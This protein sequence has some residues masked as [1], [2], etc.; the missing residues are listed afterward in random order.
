MAGRYSLSNKRYKRLFQRHDN[1]IAERQIDKFNQPETTAYLKKIGITKAG[2]IKKIW[3]ATK[4]YPYYLNLIRKQKDNGKP[5]KLS[6][7]GRDMVDLLLADFND[8]E[9]RVIYLASYCRWFDQSI[10]QHLLESNKIDE[11][12]TE[13]SSW[14]EW[15]VNRDFVMEDDHYRFDNVA[16]DIIRRTEY[17]NNK[18][19]LNFVAIH[20]QLAEYFQIQASTKVDPEESLSDKYQARDWRENII[21]STYHALF[22]DK[23]QG[24]IQLLTHFFEGAYL[25]DPEIAIKSF[26][27]VMGEAD[28]DD[29]EL[30]PGNTKSFLQSVTLAIK[31]GWVFVDKNPERYKISF[32]SEDNEDIAEVSKAFKSEIESALN[33]LLK[34]VDKLEG[35]AKCAGLIG[36]F[37]RSKQRNKDLLILEQAKAEMKKLGFENYSSLSFLII[38]KAGDILFDS[39]RYEEA[40][41][42]YNQAIEL[43]PNNDDAWHDRGSTL[44]R[45]G[46]Y[47]EAL[48]NYN[49]AIKLN[50]KEVAGIA[51]KGI[52]LTR[53]RKYT[54]AE[55][56]IKQAESMKSESEYVYY[57]KACFHA[58][59]NNEQQALE[60][61]EKAINI[62]PQKCRSEAKTNPDF[63]RL[64]DNPEFTALFTAVLS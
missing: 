11:L 47:E 6:R 3:K 29:F 42:N 44:S 17:K 20:Q 13:G 23:N 10:I 37:V 58:L 2:E 63:D 57:A 51:N 22:A 28:I 26:T 1:L 45:L 7:G 31:F 33:K 62:A 35:L 55:K 54:E 5:I 14:F 43:A 32:K 8:L 64:K 61:L 48:T 34:E 41:T 59:Q 25:K 9:K 40:I 56:C 30:L 53:Q 16:R 24:Q 15:L 60:N 19:N 39:G 46:R 36:K 38:A 27:A 50:P 49:Q 52:I 21:E 12:S 4:G 18:H